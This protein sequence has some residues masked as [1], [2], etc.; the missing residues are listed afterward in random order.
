MRMIF[1][2]AEIARAEELGKTDDRRAVVSG[3]LR[4]AKRLLDV[5]VRIVTA[6]HLHEAYR[7]LLVHAR[8]ES[9]SWTRYDIG[10]KKVVKQVIGLACFSEAVENGLKGGVRCNFGIV[11]TVAV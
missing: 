4:H 10:L 2:L 9:G 7:N 8:F 6:L 11:V 1:R 5:R 3:V